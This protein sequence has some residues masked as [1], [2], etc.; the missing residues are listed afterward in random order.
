MLALFCK[1]YAVLA[2][3]EFNHVRMHAARSP[4]PEK[5]GLL[6]WLGEVDN[7]TSAFPAPPQIQ[8]VESLCE[9]T[10]VKTLVS[11]E[12]VLYMCQTL[13]SMLDFA[14]ALQISSVVHIRWH[15]HHHLEI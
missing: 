14:P 4:P 8:P 3:E 11:P 13:L 9:Y 10:L 1:P 7:R 6:P 12:S 15:G 5:L 2:M